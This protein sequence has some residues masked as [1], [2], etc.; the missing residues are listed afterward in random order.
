VWSLVRRAARAVYFRELRQLKIRVALWVGCGPVL[1]LIISRLIERRL[2]RHVP[3]DLNAIMQIH[4]ST[5]SMRRLEC[6]NAGWEAH[7]SGM[8]AR[9]SQPVALLHH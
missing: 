2:C 7:A 9:S 6:L 5:G 3:P 1:S 4:V 8:L